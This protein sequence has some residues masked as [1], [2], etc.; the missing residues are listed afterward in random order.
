MVEYESI[1]DY[2]PVKNFDNIAYR[3]ID[4]C[5]IV[6]NLKKDNINTFNSTA[7]KIWELIDG[8]TK[9]GAIIEKVSQVYE[10][11]RDRLEK[12]C[13]EFISQLQY[14]GLVILSTQPIGD[15][16]D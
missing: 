7:T 2:L 8:K 16:Y 10:V 15:K 14:E 9:I 3:V 6:V 11:S 4:G 13:C 12:D 5:A 1:M